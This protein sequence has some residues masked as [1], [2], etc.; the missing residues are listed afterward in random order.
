MVIHLINDSPHIDPSEDL[1]S[2]KLIMSGAAPL[3]ATDIE[4]FFDVTKGKIGFIQAY[5][6]TESSPLTLKQTNAF[7][8]GIKIG[9]SGLLIPNTE[10]KF[11]SLENSYC[12][13]G[14]GIHECG[15]LL[16]R[17]PQVY[18]CSS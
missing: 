13:D 1:A 16:I 15:E 3:G 18:S 10:A 11:I 2:V 6:M 4:R 12:L 5:G 17:G 7:K 14:L 9:G 8:W